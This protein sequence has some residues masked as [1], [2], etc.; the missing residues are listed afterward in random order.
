MNTVG[1]LPHLD[2]LR[3]VASLM[4]LFNHLA[5]CFIPPMSAPTPVGSQIL[6]DLRRSPLSVIWGG[7]FGV[8]IFFALSGVVLARLSHSSGLNFPSLLL[9]RYVRLALPMLASTLLGYLLL[10]LSLDDNVAAANG[11]S[12]SRWLAL[13]YNFPPDLASA[14]NEGLFGAFVNGRSDYNSNLWTMQ[15]ELVGSAVIFALYS[16]KTRARWRLAALLVLIIVLPGYY[17]LFA[18]GA[19]LFEAQSLS[20]LRIGWLRRRHRDA[21]GAICFLAAVFAGGF[22]GS[23]SD[24]MIT[25]SWHHWLSASRNAQAWHTI[26]ATLLL[27]AV[28]CSQ[29]FATCLGSRTGRML[30]RLSFPIYLVQIPILCSFTS[31]SMLSL[32]DLPYGDMAAATTLMTLLVTIALAAA[33]WWLVE[34]PSVR[35]SQR[36]GRFV[37][38]W[39]DRALRLSHAWEDRSGDLFEQRAFRPCIYTLESA[40]LVHNLHPASRVRLAI[41]WL[42]AGWDRRAIRQLRRAA[43]ADAYYWNSDLNAGR[44]ASDDDPPRD[45]DTSFGNVG[46]LLSGY[47]YAAMRAFQVGAGHLSTDL[48]ARAV[49]LQPRLKKLARPGRHAADYLA[50]HGVSTDQFRVMAPNWVNQIGHLGMLDLMLRMRRLGWWHGKAVVLAPPQRIANTA[51]FSLLSAQPDV[52]AITEDRDSL[53]MRDFEALLRSHGLFRSAFRPPGAEYVR[54][55]EAAAMALHREPIS[56]T[57]TLTETFDAQFSGRSIEEDFH[58]AMRAWGIGE[59]DWYVCLHLREPGYHSAAVD[60]G[61]GNRNAEFQNYVEAIRFVTARGGRV[62]KMGS[63]D[64]PAVPTI[65]G[66]IDYART[67]F[68]SEAMDIALIRHARYF[69]GTTSG[70]ANV[71]ISFGIPTAQVNCITTEYQPWTSSV[72]FCLKPVFDRAGRMLTQRGITSDARWWLATHQTMRDAGFSSADNTPDEILETVRDV[73]ALATG[74][75]DTHAASG[76][77]NQWRRHL[78]VPHAYGAASPSLHFLDKHRA[79]FLPD[80]A[81]ESAD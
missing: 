53:L 3:G 69:I 81:E 31:W 14:I 21:I 25:S 29:T 46:L 41:C 12:H 63:P 37:N 19:A 58:R 7:D 57:W 78:A 15:I 47:N 61:Q 24:T 75:R 44:R 66:L 56:E 49:A 68:K 23:G 79:A 60:S 2:G 50:A 27:A 76:I 43:D 28:L 4:V 36:V 34:M 54:W 8:C 32:R 35:L 26:G 71:A 52:L 17:R 77:F 9:R 62:I 55:H 73:D 1:R 45:E 64:A 80:S 16:F 5:L 65:P 74:R 59:G 70:L 72:R 20:A 48:G 30:G 39:H 33:F 42:I 11:I 18:I 13:W 10:K 51:F 22:P 67:A 40:A 6:I 38:D